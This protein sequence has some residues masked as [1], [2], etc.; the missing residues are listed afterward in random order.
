MNNTWTAS[1][2]TVAQSAHHLLT[3]VWPIKAL[4]QLHQLPAMCSKT[5]IFSQ[6]ALNWQHK[7]LNQSWNGTEEDV[8]RRGTK[9]GPRGDRL[10][11]RN[12]KRRRRTK[13]KTH[14]VQ[15]C[16]WGGGG[17]AV[18]KL[19]GDRPRSDRS[20]R[21][22]RRATTWLA[23]GLRA[24]ARGHRHYRALPSKV[25]TLYVPCFLPVNFQGA[26]R[27]L[28]DCECQSCC[29]RAELPLSKSPSRVHE[30]RVHLYT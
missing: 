2:E 23:A 15:Q 8:G 29:W 28:T 24:R 22:G 25:Q 17:V 27:V 19:V 26:L 4:S 9:R 14:I 16:W 18:W 3:M 1:Q 12:R 13:S 21:S 5:H 7:A 30:A 11:R 20:G 6:K 10:N